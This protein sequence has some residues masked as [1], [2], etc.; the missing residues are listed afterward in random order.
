MNSTGTNNTMKSRLITSNF[1]PR[2][3]LIKLAAAAIRGA[4]TLVVLSVLLTARPAQAQA[5]SVLYNFCDTGSGNCLST[6]AYPQGRLTPDGRGN[7]YGVTF[8]GGDND[9]GAVFEL[10]ANGSEKIIYSFGP[11]LGGMAPYLSYVI[12]DGD[13]N[14]YGTASTGGEYDG[15]VVY[16]LTPAGS[17]YVLYSF[18]GGTDG[19]S[20]Y[21]GLVMDTA[22]NLYGITH[23]GGTSGNGYVFEL[24]LS[25]GS[26]SEQVIYNIA[27]GDSIVAG[28]AMDADGNLFGNTFFTVFELSPN[29]GWNPTVL[30]TF[31]SG[32]DGGEAFGVP[33][34]D[35]AGNI[36]G[37][38][39]DGGA[40]KGGTVY[41]VSPKLQGK[42]VKWTE[43]VLYSFK[44]NLKDGGGPWAGVALDAAG[45]I[46][47]TTVAGGKYTYGTVFKLAPVGTNGH[48]ETTLWN[49]DGTTGAEAVG[50]LIL[51]SGNLYGTAERGGSGA[52]TG[53]DGVVFEVT[54]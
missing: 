51:Y 19:G 49:F 36:Y 31:G 26:W 41:E 1:G 50:S 24:S 38:T 37:T 40:H 6:G 52:G 10:L 14:L 27:S 32:K 12:L 42:K 18:P 21:S 17:E 53:G 15:G 4:L 54:P 3:S 44:N 5:Y 43:R 48:K 28:L 16:E 25:N 7:F 20:P 8:G 23:V 35:G 33:V 34:L 29:G 11:G 45:N 9:A 30:H 46:Y 2:F 13:G 39:H 47:G 22:G